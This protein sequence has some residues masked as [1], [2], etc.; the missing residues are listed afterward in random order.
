MNLCSIKPSHV[1]L[2]CTGKCQ[3]NF[4]VPVDRTSK[5]CSVCEIV[6]ENLEPKI[7]WY[8]VLLTLCQ[9]YMY[10]RT[11]HT[12]RTPCMRC[13]KKRNPLRTDSY[14]KPGFCS[15]LLYV[16]FTFSILLWPIPILYVIFTINSCSTHHMCLQII[17][18][19]IRAAGVDDRCYVS[20]VSS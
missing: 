15:E 8:K 4:A 10:T 7:W 1:C 12:R 9:V 18:H 14:T 19:Q 6:T 17:V 20:I 16:I 3:Q 13:L 2:S 11:P 5:N